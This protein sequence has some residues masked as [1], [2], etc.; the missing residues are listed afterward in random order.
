M[1]GLF[2]KYNMNKI[3]LFLLALLV[4]SCSLFKSNI[5]QPER[6]FRGFWVATVVNIDWPKNGHDAV[7]KQKKD[8]LA[9]LDFYQ[10][11]NFNAAIVQVRTAGDAF[12]ESDYAPWSRYLTGEEGVAPKTEENILHWMISETHKRGMEFHA[13]LNPYRATFNLDTESLSEKHDYNLYPDWMLKYG[14]KYYYNPGLPDVQKHLVTIIEEVVAQYDIDAIHFDDYFYPYKIKDEVFDDASS[15]K[16]YGLP[17]QS[18]DDWRRSNVDSLVQKIHKNIKQEKPW[19]QFGV[20]P[21]G[22]WKNKSTDPKG[23]D[24]QAGQTNYDDLYANPILWMEQGWID[25]IIPQAYWSL[26]LP[27]A[28]HKVISEWWAENSPN[29]NLYMGNGP[30]KIRNNDD[31]AWDKKRELPNQ[32]KLARNIDKVQGNAFFS[33]KSLPNANDDVVTILKRNYYAQ[34]ALPPISH[35]APNTTP[36]TP[37][38]ISKKTTPDKLQ[39]SFDNLDPYRY[40]LVYKAKANQTSFSLK[41][42]LVPLTAVNGNTLPIST[43]MVKKHK[44]IAIAFTDKFGQKTEPIFILLK[45]N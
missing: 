3:P 21:F 44:K 33:A 10:K 40:A 30:Y 9:L 13:W 39:L 24:T 1:L 8:Y 31:K 12:Y 7:E 15:Y 16:T 43:K 36:A 19:V 25:Y 45:Q 37:I 41:D 18:L 32:I 29:T 28:S 23:S 22:V 27:V 26:N 34:M 35:L 4:S 11:M 6:E 42:L 20:S 2:I 17:N 38:L 5:P 14:K